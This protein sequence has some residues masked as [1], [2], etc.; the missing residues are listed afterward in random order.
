MSS[1][2]AGCDP[3]AASPASAWRAPVSY[4]AGLAR[5][6]TVAGA[7][8]VEVNRPNRQMRRRRGKTDTVDAEAAARTALDR[9]VVCAP[10]SADGVVEAIRMV[11]VAR[12]GAV[13]A[14]T[15]AAN[16]ISGLVVSAPEHLKGRLRGLNTAAVVQVCARW[17]PEPGPDTPSATN[18]L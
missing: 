1:C 4:G 14:R 3:T 10:K 11:S 16:Q 12:R 2:W 8:V 13:K 17:R 18:C 5:H 9:A 7:E 6:L 15:Q